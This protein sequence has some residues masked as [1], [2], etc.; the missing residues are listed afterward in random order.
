MLG[1]RVGFHALAIHSLSNNLRAPGDIESTVNLSCIHLSLHSYQHLQLSLRATNPS[2][3][4]RA[5]STTPL[6]RASQSRC[7]PATSRMT[8]RSAAEILTSN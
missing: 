8:S 3:C 5:Y 1:A 6:V 4:L 7:R 2:T